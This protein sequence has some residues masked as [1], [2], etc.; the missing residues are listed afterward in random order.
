MQVEKVYFEKCIRVNLF[1]LTTVFNNIQHT[2]KH[3]NTHP[4]PRAPQLLW[5]SYALQNFRNISNADNNS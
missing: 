1:A 4:V 3:I 2:Q 5:Q